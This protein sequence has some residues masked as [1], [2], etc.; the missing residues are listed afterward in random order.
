MALY[1]CSSS[2]SSTNCSSKSDNML[3]LSN[4][5]SAGKAC[6]GYQ[7]PRHSIIWGSAPQ[8]V[9]I[10][11]RISCRPTVYFWTP[12]Y[13]WGIRK[14]RKGT[15][16]IFIYFCLIR[17]LFIF[18]QSLMTGGC[19]PLGLEKMWLFCIQI[20]VLGCMAVSGRLR[21]NTSVFLVQRKLIKRGR[22][23]TCTHQC[24]WGEG[25]F[26]GVNLYSQFPPLWTISW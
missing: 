18:S 17:V 5:S 25:F 16:N 26:F 1:L 14:L 10:L 21:A 8:K 24:C 23:F 13:F 9:A 20:L 11:Q 22:Q 4:H 15:S 7:V 6:V 3:G 2:P 19:V 12:Q